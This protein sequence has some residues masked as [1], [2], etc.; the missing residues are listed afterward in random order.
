[1]RSVIDITARINVASPTL[2]KFNPKNS[3]NFP[4]I[5]CDILSVEFVI[6]IKPRAAINETLI[7]SK[8]DITT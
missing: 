8:K 4:T 3:S 6:K 2:V 5:F 7:S 1:M